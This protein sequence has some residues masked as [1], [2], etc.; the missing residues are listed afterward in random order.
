MNL[1]MRTV[2]Q[3]GRRWSKGSSRGHNMLG[4]LY[5]ARLF[6]DEEI[7]LLYAKT[8]LCLLGAPFF[9]KNRSDLELALSRKI[10][11]SESK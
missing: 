10:S 8:A 2:K 7:F 3:N 9:S 4:P 5:H 6:F 11:K 1:L